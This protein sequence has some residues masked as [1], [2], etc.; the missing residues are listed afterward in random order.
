MAS[1][2]FNVSETDQSS[3]SSRT[4]RSIVINTEYVMNELGCTNRII[5]TQPR[6]LDQFLLLK[7]FIDNTKPKLIFKDN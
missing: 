2:S 1:H 5:L 7:A 6:L 3:S 4:S